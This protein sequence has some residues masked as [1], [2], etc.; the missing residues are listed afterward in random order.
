MSRSENWITEST[1]YLESVGIAVD[2]IEELQLEGTCAERD[3]PLHVWSTSHGELK[4][5]RVESSEA[6]ENHLKIRR[7][8]HVL[9]MP[10][11]VHAGAG[12]LVERWIEGRPIL[13][14][15]VD[16]DF[17]YLLGDLV[18]AF[19]TQP[20]DLQAESER[21]RSGR[22]LE[23]K[24]QEVLT[25][26]QDQ[27]VLAPESCK[28]LF[29]R[30]IG[31]GPVR[32]ESGFVH[33]DIKPENIVKTLNGIVFID[34]ETLSFGPLD[35]EL[36]RLWGFWKL[37]PHDRGRFLDGYGNHRST[38]SFLLHEL[39]WSIY[40]LMGSL[41]YRIRNRLP[42]QDLILA[43]TEIAQGDLPFAWFESKAVK[44]EQ[45]GIARIRVAF[46]MDYLAIGGQERVCYEMLR[47]LDR[48]FF[49][50]HLYAFRGGAMAKPFQALGI[51]VMIGS[52]RDPL[53]S[54]EWTIQDGI[55]KADYDRRLIGALRDDRIDAA[56][57]FSWK[58]APE[59]LRA[60][61]IQVAIDK[62]DGPSLLGKIKDKSG[63]QWIV[64]ESETLRLE[65]KNRQ[66]EYT[67]SETKLATIHSCIDLNS[68]DPKVWNK[69]HERSRLGLRDDHL[70]I[71]FVGRLIQGKDVG[72]L[73]RAFAR[74]LTRVQELADRCIL[75][76]C[77][78]DGGALEGILGEVQRLQL[79]DHFRYLSPPENVAQVMS[80][81][82]IFAMSSKSEGLP[83]VIL[84]AMSMG[85]PI[86]STATGSIPEVVCEN[87]YVSEIGNWKPFVTHLALLAR[88]EG[89]RQRM[90]EESRRIAASF[91]SRHAVG[92]YEELILDALLELRGKGK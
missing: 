37:T 71:G 72:F 63:F 40:A 11:V 6:L 5:R 75:L 68:F 26:F 79:E 12:F 1:E 19:A 30:A 80:V 8:N 48:R 18:G 21:L 83:T 29:K 20:C 56:L 59:V 47:S 90:G 25:E 9:P 10:E 23:N 58:T 33:L 88:S 45:L 39:F 3:S 36:A 51:P 35:Y 77:G 14:S 46:L 67:F 27:G 62:L 4:V 70:V 49:E 7:A 54:K 85:L 65:M 73:V 64:A 74:F 38:K 87:G 57:V 34:N 32:V 31:N 78:P 2:R 91:A 17:M 52:D 16:G 66:L 61:G 82:D 92:R 86:V 55:E 60:A 81:F 22:S 41:R 69:S 76:I 42:Y 89:K 24:L 43:I 44:V 50:P 53:A 13:P 84:E 28:E 15:D